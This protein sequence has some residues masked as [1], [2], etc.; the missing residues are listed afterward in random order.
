ML[1]DVHNAVGVLLFLLNHWNTFP[2]VARTLYCA[3]RVVQGIA[4]SVRGGGSPCYSAVL[5][6]RVEPP[7]FRD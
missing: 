6:I 2:A 4:C 7:K 5:A 1:V 3:V